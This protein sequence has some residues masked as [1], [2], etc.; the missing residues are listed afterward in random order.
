MDSGLDYRLDWS[1]L[2]CMV[3]HDGTSD[4]IFALLQSSTDPDQY[5]LG[6]VL[7]PET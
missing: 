3:Y 5:I 4:I 6:T 1:N 2:I 7:R